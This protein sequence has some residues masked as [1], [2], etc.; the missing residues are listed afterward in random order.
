MKKFTSTFLL[1]LVFVGASV[2]QENKPANSNKLLAFKFSAYT[3]EQDKLLHEEF[4]KSGEYKITYSCIPA[5]I[6][7][8]ASG[9]EVTDS[10]KVS[11]TNKIKNIKGALYFT[12][13]EGYTQ[14]QAEHECSTARIIQ[15][16]NNPD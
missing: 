9:K 10:E 12:S 1:F 6:V 16:T 14:Q 2:A 8:I 11:V 7:V 15:Y 4:N 3:P 13:L 5:G